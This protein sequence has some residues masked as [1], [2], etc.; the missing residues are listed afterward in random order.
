MKYFLLFKTNFSQV[1]QPLTIERELFLPKLNNNQLQAGAEQPFLT[2]RAIVLFYFLFSWIFNQ[3][4]PFNLSNLKVKKGCSAP[5]V[6]GKRISQLKVFPILSIILVFSFGSI[7]FAQT[8]VLIPT[9]ENKPDEKILSLADMN[10]EIVIDNQHATVRVV[11]IFENHTNQTLEGKYLFALPTDAA[12]SDF[13]VWD[14]DQ[15][16][17]GVMMEIRRAEAVY[18]E[19]KQQKVDPG[20]LQ[21]NDEKGGASAFSAQIFPINPFS[22]KRLEME[23]TQT[24]SLENLMSHFV[25]PLK[26]SYGE[27]QRVGKFRLNVRV[28]NDIDFERILKECDN[29]PLQ[30]IRNEPN[31]LVGEFSAENIELKEDFAFDYQLKL[32]GNR[33]SFITYRAPET[34]SVYELRNPKLANPNPDGYF[35]AQAFFQQLN[36]EQISPRRVTLL[37]DTSLSMYGDKLTK[38]VE[39]IDYFLHNLNENDEFSLILFNSDTSSFTEKPVP[40][41]AEN[42]EKALQ[43][44]RQ[45]TLAGGTNLKKTFEKALEQTKFFSAGERQIVLISDANPTLE[46]QDSDKISVVFEQK[47]AENIRFF[48]FAIGTD[49][50]ESLLQPLA[51]KTK[52]YFAQVKET[53]D[54][55]LSLKLFLS[56][57]GAPT[58]ESL[59]FDSS[60]TSNFYQVYALDNNIFTDSSFAFVGRYKNPKTQALL[61]ITGLFGTENLLL[62]NQFMLPEF[63]DKHP[64]LPRVWA[65]ARIRALLQEIDRNGE[66]TGLINEIIVLS[67]KYK[68]VTPYTAFIAA[69]RSLLRPRLIQPGDPIIRIKTDESITSVF[70]VLPFGETLPL[71][72]LPIEGVWETRFLAPSWMKD[73]TYKC[74]I[75]LTDKNGNGYQEEKTFVVDSKSPNVKINLR[76]KTVRAGDEL[77]IRVNADSDTNRLTAKFYGAKPIKLSWSN[78]EKANFGKLQIPVNLASGKYTLTIVAEDFA[79]NQTTE[80][81]EVEVLGR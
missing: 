55:E 11:Q 35:Q 27:T 71:T 81:I 41:N 16:I 68:I 7:S 28:L 30:I 66:T 36:T 26:P 48:A 69:P 44:I 80:N 20:I 54:I 17:P 65:N 5:A 77:E 49:A 10:V 25:F 33:L 52:G 62:E 72:F 75:L 19:I 70:A 74:R 24:F 67:Q 34:I 37:L 32:T 38:A 79:H 56:K 39:A 4:I 21:T 13:A 42:V 31:Y 2:L 3:V 12:V 59:Q 63:D 76:E 23:Y 58:I 51:E 6:F 14:G 64:H 45:S 29:Y 47:Q 1:L 57:L 18:G 40:V 22:T 9:S 73:G 78:A 60:A 43:F 8:G 50:N 61:R 15:R 46:T 53:E